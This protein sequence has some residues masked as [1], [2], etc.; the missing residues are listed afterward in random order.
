MDL[1]QS[2]QQSRRRNRII[3]VVAGAITTIA[4][5]LAFAAGYLEQ[6]WKWLR[7]AAELLLLAEL[8]GL[9]VLERHQLFE[10]VSEKVT[11]IEA[12]IAEMQAMIGQMNERMAAAGQVVV[13]VGIREAFQL[14]TRLLREALARDYEGPQLLRL[15]V[16]SGVLVVEDMRE[17]GDELATLT[18]TLSEFLLMPSSGPNSKAHRWSARLILAWATIRSFKSGMEWFLPIFEEVGALNVEVK[19]LVR[20]QPE[21]MLSPAQ[22]TDRDVFVTYD[23]ERGRYRWGLS[24]QGRQYVALCAQWFDDRWSSIPDSY[25]IYSRKGLDQKAVDQIKRELEAN[26]AARSENLPH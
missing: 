8:V 7:P 26:D 13:T 12:R 16:L 4:I 14:R 23:N 1:G 17:L 15:A 21:A 5:V 19:I 20:A 2:Q 11:G 9:I 3:A 18:K 10:P 6:P 25:L 22:I 24:L